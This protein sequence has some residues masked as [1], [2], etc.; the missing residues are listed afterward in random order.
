MYFL[1]L[2][3]K[4]LYLLLFLIFIQWLKHFVCGAAVVWEILNIL[5][6]FSHSLLCCFFNSFLFNATVI[7]VGIS[8]GKITIGAIYT[9][10]TILGFIKFVTFQHRHIWQLN[11]QISL[12]VRLPWLQV[13]INQFIIARWWR[14][15]RWFWTISSRIKWQRTQL[16]QRLLILLFLQFD[17][18]IRPIFPLDPSINTHDISLIF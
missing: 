16:C 5:H 2:L 14:G 7:T 8:V 15:W 6:D 9:T 13:R 11:L 10:V 18:I 17:S 1:A 12:Q 3:N 4:D